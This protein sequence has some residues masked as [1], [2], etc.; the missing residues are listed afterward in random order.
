[1]L[2]LCVKFVFGDNII[3]MFSFGCFGK[4]NSVTLKA[5]FEFEILLLHHAQL[6]NSFIMP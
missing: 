3:C 5:G 6:S 4:N 2:L 1:M